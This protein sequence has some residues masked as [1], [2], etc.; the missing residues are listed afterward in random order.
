MDEYLTQLISYYSLPASVLDLLQANDSI[1]QMHKGE[2][3]CPP[4]QPNTSLCFLQSGILRCFFI[5]SA[6]EDVT[7]AFL[8]HYGDVFSGNPN[9]F[10]QSQDLC[11]NAQAMSACTLLTFDSE[12]MMSY[13]RETPALLELSCRILS[14][15][16]LGEWDHER[17]LS[18]PAEARYRWFLNK[19]PGLI[20]HVVHGCIASFLGITPVTLSRV[21]KKLEREDAQNLSREPDL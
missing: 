17:I 7:D 11:A 10:G 21:R 4:N 3:L 12:K 9:L 16:Y 8:Y 20:D 18:C 1:R 6:G 15:C 13:V 19:Y 2:L 5:N 14:Q